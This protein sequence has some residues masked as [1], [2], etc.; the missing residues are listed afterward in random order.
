[1]FQQ[2]SKNCISDIIKLQLE[3]V[4]NRLESRRI[5]LEF[6]DNVIDF[7]C[8]RGYDPAMGARPIKR[9][10]QTY[11]ENVLA[12]VLLSGE[13]SENCTVKADVSPDKNGLVF[14]KQQ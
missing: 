4:Q 8:E 3:H 10:I 14:T 6:T 7:L 2:L 13:I 12:K 1:M 11:V 9:A 5:K